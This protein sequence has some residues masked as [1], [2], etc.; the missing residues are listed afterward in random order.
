MNFTL[1]FRLPKQLNI[2]EFNAH[3]FLLLIPSL[4]SWHNFYLVPKKTCNVFFCFSAHFISSRFRRVRSVYLLPLQNSKTGNLELSLQIVSFLRLFL[5]YLS[6]SSGFFCYTNLTD[7]SITKLDFNAWDFWHRIRVMT[8]KR[9]SD[10]I[11]SDS[12]CKF[13]GNL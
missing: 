1:T 2:T 10:T 12:N 11:C 5:F 6:R 4:N 3:S 7:S 13:R 8:N 9:I